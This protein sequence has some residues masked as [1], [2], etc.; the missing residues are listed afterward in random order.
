MDPAIFGIVA[1][2]VLL[3]GG[4]GFMGYWTS[5]QARNKW[6]S[7]PTLNEYLRKHPECKT[8]HGIKCSACSSGSIRNWGVMGP[9]DPARIFKC[10]HC[11]L[12]LYRNEV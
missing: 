6:L 8:A 9:R 4:S 1:I 12:S 2:V 10:N 11:G 7:N 5:R 3:I